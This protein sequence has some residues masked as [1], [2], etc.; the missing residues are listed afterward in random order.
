MSTW[1][2]LSFKKK[3][4]IYLSKGRLKLDLNIMIYWLYFKIENSQ[5][6]GCPNASL[7]GTYSCEDNKWWC[8]LFY[9]YS[10]IGRCNA[11]ASNLRQCVLINWYHT[12]AANNPV[13]FHVLPFPIGKTSQLQEYLLLIFISFKCRGTPEWYTACPEF[14]IIILSL[15]NFWGPC[16]RCVNHL[17][18]SDR[19]SYERQISACICSF[20]S[21]RIS[22]MTL[23]LLLDYW[24]TCDV[25]F[26]LS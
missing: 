18:G 8:G 7:S 5:I 15:P 3:I 26:F 22:T 17:P 6:I 14:R 20:V 12:A 11:S 10:F 19:S 24:G 21:K 16:W 2:F 13:V 9:S 23:S 1:F 25:F 4:Y